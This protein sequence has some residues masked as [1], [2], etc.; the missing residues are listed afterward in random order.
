MKVPIVRIESDNGYKFVE[1]NESD[2][3]KEKHVLYKEEVVKKPKEL[4]NKVKK[5]LTKKDEK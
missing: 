1:I 2:F 5:K 4:K 3:D